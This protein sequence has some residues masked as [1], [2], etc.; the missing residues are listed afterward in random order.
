M[1]DR[2][3]ANPQ[4]LLLAEL[5]A[6]A[7]IATMKCCPKCSSQYSDPTLSFCLQDGTP[8]VAQKQ[9]SV[10]TVSFSL[11][12]LTSEKIFPTQELPAAP[13]FQTEACRTHEFAPQ[14]VVMPRRKSRAG[15]IAASILIPLFLIVAVIGTAGL[16]FVETREHQAEEKKAIEVSDERIETTKATDTS[17]NDPGIDPNRSVKPDSAETVP[18]NIEAVRKEITEIVNAWKDAAESRKASEYSAM[19]GEKVD[20]FD[21]QGVAQ[22]EVRA[23]I[24]KIFDEY[25]EIDLEITNLEVAVDA[26]GDAATAVFDKEW[27]Y[28]AKPKL[29]EGKAHTKLHFR[30]VGTAWK[31]VAEEYLKIYDAEN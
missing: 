6:S 16:V 14:P 28:E 5:A 12:P 31:I 8:L 9:S 17:A 30:K 18:A 10:D 25:N 1:E 29:T 21:K 2:Q 20:Y 24:Q 13:Q 11:N 15:L 3:R 22:S 23:E 4:D 26:A 7:Q 27:S 19:Y